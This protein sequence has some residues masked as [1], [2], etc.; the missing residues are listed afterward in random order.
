M[1]KIDWNSRETRADFYHS[2]SWRILREIKLS[3]DPLCEE[4]KK[5]GILTP[6]TEVHHIVDIYEDPSLRL[7][8][9][10]LQGLCKSCHSQKTVAK[11]QDLFKK[12]KEWDL[13][14]RKW[15]INIKEK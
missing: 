6:A 15:N 3:N 8:Y 13:V 11:L 9:S 2:P 10:N 12:S 1:K 7:E 14:N 5:K 4:C